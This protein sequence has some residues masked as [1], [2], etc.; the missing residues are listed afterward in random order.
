MIEVS[1]YSVP[2]NSDVNIS[3]GHCV[4][5][6]RFDKDELNTS[7]MEFVKGFLRNN[8]TN[9]E[10]AIKN[11]GIVN[12]INSEEVMNQKDFASIN[13]WLSKVG[14]LVKI[15]NVTEDEENPNGVSGE[16]AE[17]NII[18]NNFRQNDYPTAIKVLS[19]TGTNIIE[20]FEKVVEQSGVFN[21]EKIGGIKNPL[22]DYIEDLKKAKENLGIIEPGIASR[23]Y[24]ILEQVGIDL[25]L[26]TGE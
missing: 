5:R 8:L 19:T 1:L 6:S 11:A 20:V 2:E 3:M 17:W 26:A 21:G 4:D 15:V 23:V 13:Y 16:S 12:F 18:D 22:K 25:F 24:D 10:P 14:Y 9:I 7:V